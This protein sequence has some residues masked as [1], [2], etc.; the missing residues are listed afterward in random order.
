[1]LASLLFGS[2]TISQAA[3]LNSISIESGPGQPLLA[4]L[5]LNRVTPDTDISCFSLKQSPTDA[6]VNLEY[7]TLGNQQA[8]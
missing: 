1:M 8:S 4:Q 5:S 7:T 6:Q 2:I 3:E